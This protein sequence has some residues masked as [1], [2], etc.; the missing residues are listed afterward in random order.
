MS[1]M[2][3]AAAAYLTLTLFLVIAIDNLVAFYFREKGTPLGFRVP[4]DR[5]IEVSRRYYRR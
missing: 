3:V 1:I 5:M 4:L 2:I